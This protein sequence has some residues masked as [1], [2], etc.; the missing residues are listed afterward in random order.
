MRVDWCKNT[1]PPI[2]THHMNKL[3]YL[4]CQNVWHWSFWKLR[5]S[6]VKYQLGH[7]SPNLRQLTHALNKTNQS[8]CA[9]ALSL[10]LSLRGSPL[11]TQTP[12]PNKC[13]PQ[14]QPWV[15]W[16][17]SGS[18]HLCAHAAAPRQQGRAGGAARVTRRNPR[19][20]SSTGPHHQLVSLG[21]GKTG[22]CLATS[23]ASS[24]SSSSVS[25][26]TPSPISP[27]RPGPTRKPSNASRS[28]AFPLLQP[29]TNPNELIRF[30]VRWWWW[31]G[32]WRNG[33][34][35]SFFFPRVYIMM[36][37]HVTE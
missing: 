11:H 26:S 20:T 29:Q 22:S 35:D 25:D 5:L 6:S 2:T 27:S 9:T 31:R 12:K 4:L 10:A 21:N 3:W 7:E 15:A 19:V 36:V 32:I 34:G 14:Q 37:C 8:Q 24:P 30:W 17:G 33:N 16:S 1:L 18:S 23:P 28:R 13:H